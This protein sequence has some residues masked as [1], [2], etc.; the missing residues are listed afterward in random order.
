MCYQET[1]KTTLVPVTRITD[2]PEAVP[3]GKPEVRRGPDVTWPGAA[4]ELPTEKI[5]DL[6]Q[7]TGI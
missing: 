3:L 4:R 1:K 7:Q 2:D 5:P 6:A